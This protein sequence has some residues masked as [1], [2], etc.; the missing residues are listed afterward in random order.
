[1]RGTYAPPPVARS[2]TPPRQGR[3]AFEYVIARTL[4]PPVIPAQAGTGSIK[5]CI[6]DFVIIKTQRR[7]IPPIK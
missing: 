1:M 7:I 4:S 5:I 6:A 3:W 2:A